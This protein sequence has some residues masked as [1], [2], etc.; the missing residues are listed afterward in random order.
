[1]YDEQLLVRIIHRAIELQYSDHMRVC[2]ESVDF[3]ATLGA[4]DSQI[5]VST[6]PWIQ[7][8]IELLFTRLL[9][10]LIISNS[11]LT[12]LL[13]FDEFFYDNVSNFA[14][15]LLSVS[16]INCSVASVNFSC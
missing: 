1:M 4:P 11:A 9:D 5:P 8:D 3:F 12:P 6:L 7:N 13:H 15:R 10:M 14:H 16:K 2:L